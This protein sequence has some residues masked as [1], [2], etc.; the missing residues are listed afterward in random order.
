[1]KQNIER[2]ISNFM[3]KAG[4][5]YSTYFN[6][7]YKRSGS[8]FQ[9]PFKSAHI[10]SNELLL[11]SSAYVNCNSEVHGIAKAENYK[12]C[13]F[14]D[15]IGK[16]N[17]TLCAKEIILGQYKSSDD[18]KRTAIE[19]AISIAERRRFGKFLIE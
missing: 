16:R 11:Y 3:L 5:G 7:K 6:E 19:T 4:S 8:L 14:P 18:Y 10:G 15:Y 1:L 12:W 17:G 13:S 2:G 9:G